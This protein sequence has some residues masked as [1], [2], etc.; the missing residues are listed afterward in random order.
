MDT[1]DLIASPKS[2]GVDATAKK[3]AEDRI[4]PPTTSEKTSSSE[5]TGTVESS[6]IPF[7]NIK[8]ELEGLLNDGLKFEG[9]FACFQRYSANGAPNPFL[10]INGLG[11]IGIPLNTREAIVMM[12]SGLSEQSPATESGKRRWEIAAAQVHVDNPE[13]E[14]WIRE[15]AGPAAL[16]ALAGKAL[17]KPI[18]KLRKLILQESGS[19]SEN[20]DRMG[21]L[22]VVLPSTFDGARLQFRHADD[23]LLVDLSHQS[24]ISTSVIAAYSGVESK[25]GPVSSGYRLSLSYDILQPT[26]HAGAK[27]FGLP[28]MQSINNRLKQILA[29][30]MEEPKSHA[31]H[32]LLKGKYERESSFGRRSLT[33]SDIHL[34]THL[35][36][37]A[38]QLGLHLHFAHVEMEITAS[39]SVE[40]MHYDGY[41]ENP[42][43]ALGKDNFH[44]NMEDEDG[45][46][47]VIQVVDLEGM[48]LN[49][50]RVKFLA[51]D[52]I[53]GHMTEYEPD[54]SDFE[55][56]DETTATC[57]NTYRRVVLLI[58]KSDAGLSPNIDAIYDYASIA[59][60]D[61][62][63]LTPSD[64]EMILVDS[65]L[66]LS[67]TCD[68]ERLRTLAHLLAES[69]D[70]WTNLSILLRTL[71]TCRVDRRID[72]LGVDMLISMYQ[73][74]GWDD[75]KGFYG[76]A[77]KNDETNLTR[78]AFL[79]GLLEMAREE[80]STE[81]IAWCKAEQDQ[82]LRD[83]R[84]FSLN[85]LEWLFEVATAR[86]GEF[87]RDVIFPQLTTQSL[88]TPFWIALMKRLQNISA[89]APELVG[90]LILTCV[91]QAVEAL[92]AFPIV[93]NSRSYPTRPEADTES[94]MEVIRACVET[95]NSH[96]CYRISA[97]MR[98]TARA[99]NSSSPPLR[100]IFYSKLAV[101]LNKYLRAT[102]V[103]AA[104]A[105]IKPF[106]ED[107]VDSML[108]AG[109]YTTFDDCDMTLQNL[110]VINMAVRMAGGMPFSKERLNAD[111]WTTRTSA[112][113]QAF[114]RSVRAEF[115]P[116]AGDIAAESE[117][118]AVT[119]ALVDAAIRALDMSTFMPRKPILSYGVILNYLRDSV[120]F[121]FQVDAAKCQ[122]LLIKL[123]E[124]PAG[125]TLPQHVDKVLVPFIPILKTFLATV[126]LDYRTEP[127]R[128]FGV[129]V[130][131][132]Y[133]NT[134]MGRQ[135][136]ELVPT[137]ELEGVGCKTCPDC[138]ALKAF[139]VEDK[140]S[141]DFSRAQA[142]RSH[143]EQYLDATT[144]WGVTWET[145]KLR[146]PHTLRVTKP[147]RMTGTGLALSTQ[148]GISLLA[149]L[150]DSAM[151]RLI[152]GG[153][154]DWILTKIAPPKK[155]TQP[156]TS[157]PAAG[158]RT[159]REEGTRILRVQ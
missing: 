141:I 71:E 108:S 43:D 151:R 53:N 58:S 85:Q 125:F 22:V 115:T 129:A 74:F 78:Q 26:T 128:M 20:S 14:V 48:P 45:E 44:F 11:A 34:I 10:R 145:H 130:I 30:W 28:D 8:E 39:D 158:G 63:S 135:P 116:P 62:R 25:L 152:L 148:K 23:T 119:S 64:R 59:L 149:E 17:V 159:R 37:L 67:E 61:S 79:T 33:G 139:F 9:T 150:G 49:A 99:E 56:E 51:T 55:R 72:L 68:A 96:L 47:S 42:Y 50:P 12:S 40:E 81:I 76:D 153:D 102:D 7:E 156:E 144:P 38:R 97:R 105:Y 131:K 123:L 154:H 101:S 89:W 60:R 113:L 106:F 31:L 103:H 100:W 70:R 16:K 140:P 80:G 122:D 57:T 110:T 90:T 36:P 91:V 107:A 84:I 146:S 142:K 117:F 24:G 83:L 134:V 147:P 111:Y 3:A 86:G 66:K 120:K 137:A 114:T 27:P 138:V 104:P 82:L 32:W 124:P 133:A 5:V 65:L 54:L 4:A 94:I 136:H 6:S 15:T 126:N 21:T 118:L 35:G 29:S 121:C 109:Q 143:L 1:G 41:G 77:M 127:F 46:L 73:A 69:A 93:T 155:T 92:R 95:G 75:L 52:V 19:Q 18:Y 112:E 132:A 87:L 13:W 2:A 157:W 88:E 98:E